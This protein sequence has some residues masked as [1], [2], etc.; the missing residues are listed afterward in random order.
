MIIL[1]PLALLPLSISQPGPQV[2]VAVSIPSLGLIA[3]EVGGSRVEV[4]S[5]LPEGAEPHSF[6]L[7]AKTVSEA[8]EA[9]VVMITGPGHCPFEDELYESLRGEVRFLTFE[10]YEEHGCRLK[11]FADVGLNIHG[12]WLD[13]ENALAVAEAI[14]E[15]LCE[16]DPGGEEYYRARVEAFSEKVSELASLKPLKGLRAVAS[17]PVEAYMCEALG[18]E[19][20]AF[21]SAG[22]GSPTGVRDMYE[23]YGRLEDDVDVL[24]VS[25]ASRWSRV[26]VFMEQ[27]SRDTGV[28]VLELRVLSGGFE[29]YTDMLRWNVDHSGKAVETEGARRPAGPVVAST[30]VA[31]ASTLLSAAMYLRGRRFGRG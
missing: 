12:Y 1:L 29:G 24:V 25:D 11:A 15:V 19:V 10:D 17:K 27:L 9:D 8:L 14:C 22:D 18:L 30:V 4:Y 13:P 2:R 6:Q 16:V 31:S 23:L 21:V 20:V 7:T 26:G 5:L 3:S 28:P